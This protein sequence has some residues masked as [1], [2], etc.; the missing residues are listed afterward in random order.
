MINELVNILVDW[1]E[2]LQR[3]ATTTIRIKSM[4]DKVKSIEMEK[5]YK[6]KEN[7]LMKGNF[8]D[9]CEEVTTQQE[10][11]AKKQRE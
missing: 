3:E 9:R 2:T 11:S 1:L 7:P 5:S 10:D 6:F 8:G 4:Q